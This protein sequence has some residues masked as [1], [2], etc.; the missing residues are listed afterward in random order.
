MAELFLVV[1]ILLLAAK[2]L[3]ALSVRLGF[4][5]VLGEILAGVALS[6]SF[7]NLLGWPFLHGPNALSP[8]MMESILR[9]LSEL[10]VLFLMFLAG[11]ETDLE[12]MAK[13]G[14]AAFW[15]AAG[16]VAFPFFSGAVLGLWAG[17]GL[18]VSAFIGA[19]LTATSVSITAQT[20]LELKQLQSKEGMA[21]LGAAV[22]DDVMGVLALSL[23]VATVL[24]PEAGGAASI[25][26]TLALMTLYFAAAIGLGRRFFEP[27]LKKVSQA[28]STQ[29]TMTAAL[30]V[31]LIYSWSAEAVGQVA[32]IT[33]AYLAGVLFSRTSFR[34]D[35]TERV[36]IFAY[37]FFVPIFLAHVGLQVRVESLGS[38]AAFT[39]LLLLIAILGK[40][41]GCGLGAYAMRF[42]PA[43]SL[44]VGV[45]MISRGEVGLI[46]ASYGLSRGVIDETIFSQMALVVIVTTLVTPIGLRFVFPSKGLTKPI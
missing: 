8:G 23:V 31:C 44:R 37:S 38:A 36:G 39:T 4:P 24:K 15:A 7:L 28:R 29:I 10:G 27:L 17:Y 26:K 45:G 32:G 42:T 18:P 33:G 21:I 16:G 14:W 46:I 11:L 30:A 2:L 19:L 3:G 12:K 25:L 40:I 20:L 43:E 41:V 13:V 1:A 35:L 34:E 6:A 22:I 9:A 5:S